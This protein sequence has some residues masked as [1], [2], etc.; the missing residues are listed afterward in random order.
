[1]SI[2]PAALPFDDSRRLTGS[3]LYFD[4]AGAVLESVGVAIDAALLDGWRARVALARRTLGGADAPLVVRRHAGGA[5]LAFEAPIDQ[6]FSATEVN[7]WAWLGTLATTHALDVGLH[8][9]GHPAAWDEASAM[10]TLRAFAAAERQP[11]LPVLLQAAEARGLTVLIDDE[12]FSIG[13]GTGVRSWP[14]KELPAID[15]ALHRRPGRCPGKGRDRSYRVRAGRLERP[16]SDRG[17]RIRCTLGS[18]LDRCLKENI[19]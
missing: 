17:G 15:A 9:P 2:L 18:E 14:L 8:A 10:H 6:L 3:N 12:V 16:D 4:G 19:P 5:A 13:E 11:E 7:E 1:M